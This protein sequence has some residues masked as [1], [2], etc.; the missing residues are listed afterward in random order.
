MDRYRSGRRRDQSGA[1]HQLER[2]RR[3][4]HA[5]AATTEPRC[6]PLYHY[7]ARWNLVHQSMPVSVETIPAD[8]NQDR[9]ARSG[10]GRAPELQEPREPSTGVR[11]PGKNQHLPRGAGGKDWTRMATKASVETKDLDRTNYY[12][13]SSTGSHSLGRLVENGYKY[14]NKINIYMDR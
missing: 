13:I 11:S 14:H 8:W 3:R 4:S 5:A 9:E 6:P 7:P 1:G 10:R 12:Y 2:W